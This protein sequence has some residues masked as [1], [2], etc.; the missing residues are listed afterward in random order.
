MPNL[1]EQEYI[2]ELGQVCP[3]C[4]ASDI[5]TDGEAN[6]DDDYAWQRVNCKDCNARWD[7]VY[8]LVGYT[9]SEVNNA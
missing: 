9:L 3:V 7:D 8:K 2:Q 6:F 5:R 1:T 4:K